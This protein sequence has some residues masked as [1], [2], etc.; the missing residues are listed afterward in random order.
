HCILPFSTD[1]YRDESIASSVSSEDAKATV[2]EFDRLLSQAKHIV[3]LDGIYGTGDK[4]APKR[5]RAY[6]A[7]AW[8]L[9]QQSD[10]IIAGYQKE[11]RG[12]P[13]GTEESV[14]EALLSGIPVVWI[15]TGA[16]PDSEGL[17]P[18]RVLKSSWDLENPS[19]SDWLDEVSGLVEKL[20]ELPGDEGPK[21]MREEA[22]ES[23]QEFYGDTQTPK[24]YRKMVWKYF[25][26]LTGG[27]SS[28]RPAKALEVEPIESHRR[29]AS[30]LS[31]H[32]TSQ[33]RGAFV[34]NFLLLIVVVMLAAGF[35]LVS[36]GNSP[37]W[38][39]LLKLAI[40]LYIYWNSFSANSR[41]WHRRGI[42]F[43]VLTEF[44]RSSNYLSPLGVATP[45][46]RLPVQ[47]GING[48][49][50]DW[51]QWLFRS[52]VRAE[53]IVTTDKGSSRVMALDKKALDQARNG[54][55]EYWVDSQIEHHRETAKSMSKMFGRLEGL[56]RW[57]IRLMLVAVIGQA[58]V[59]VYYQVSDVDSEGAIWRWLVFIGAVA[60]A[61]VASFAGILYQSEA[62]R[63][64][65][66]SAALARE[67]EQW[68]QRL[69]KAPAQPH[70]CD[71]WALAQNA[72]LIAQLVADEVA[73]WHLF[74][75][76]HEVGVT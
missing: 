72:L 61:A 16:K 25:L 49:Q 57:L 14:K 8:F 42:D 36:T 3:E 41:K 26:K 11:E 15:D 70:G 37:I 1:V 21:A 64:T 40:I 33:Y 63:L 18:I 13:G 20:V 39:A 32:Y 66:R 27:A 73:D 52:I 38:L 60:P 58:A 4:G 75:Q 7:A 34:I 23:M 9:L 43:R 29:R 76:P 50:H 19:S 65:D 12:L 56:S 74:N 45:S 22:I 59:E 35:E 2:K 51:S 31:R 71:S 5:H 44:L 55:V 10:V 24:S 62:R 46:A 68:N 67:L 17:L 53:P 54:V 28:M 6:Q 30:S 47:Y 69:I 48:L